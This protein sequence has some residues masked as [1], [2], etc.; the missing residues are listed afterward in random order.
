MKNTEEKSLNQEIDE[1]IEKAAT[2]LSTTHPGQDVELKII[3]RLLQKR[4]MD[5][6][7]SEVDYFK[8]HAISTLGTDHEI[9]F[10]DAERGFLQAA[11]AD[12]RAGFKEFIESIPVDT[13]VSGDGMKMTNHGIQK[14]TS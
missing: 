3:E 14:K 2:L 1:Q 8:Q 13:P 11:L 12:G 5:V 10:N 4:G 9:D 7:R 6:R